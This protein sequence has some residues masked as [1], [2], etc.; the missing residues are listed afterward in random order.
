MLFCYRHM[1]VSRRTEKLDRLQR[2]GHDHRLVHIELELARRPSHRDRRVVAHN[3]R[4]HHGERLTLR[5]VNLARHDAGAGLVGGQGQLTEAGAGT[6]G[7]IPKRL[8]RN[9]RYIIKIKL[10][11][12]A[13]SKSK[14]CTYL[15][16]NTV[17][18]TTCN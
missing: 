4:A 5:G 7:E 15:K 3:A 9:Q 1:F 17:L 6:G 18:T 16:N 12:L 10:D 11:Q 2:R 14:P 13:D 8:L